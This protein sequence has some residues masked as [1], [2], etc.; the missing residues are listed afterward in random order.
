MAL[1]TAIEIMSFD[2]FQATRSRVADLGK[3]FRDEQFDPE[4]PGYV[5]LHGTLWVQDRDGEPYWLLIERSEYS[6]TDLDEI[7]RALYNYAVNDGRI[8]ADEPLIAPAGQIAESWVIIWKGS[9]DELNIEQQF[10][11]PF[12]SHDA[13]YDY[14]CTMPAPKEG[15]HKYIQLLAQGFVQKADRA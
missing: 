1:R 13:A 3:H 11:G 7:E 14:L 6:T 12:S 9:A 5:Y 4:T 2:E 15:G 8:I 10:I